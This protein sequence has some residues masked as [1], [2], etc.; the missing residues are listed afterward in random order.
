VTSLGPRVTLLLLSFFFLPQPEDCAQKFKDIIEDFTH[1]TRLEALLLTIHSPDPLQ[2][3]NDDTYDH[4]DDAKA[5]S[6]TAFEIAQLFLRV[7]PS[8]ARVA[9]RVVWW[10]QS[11]GPIPCFVR[12]DNGM[13]K[14]EGFDILT[15]RSWEER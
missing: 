4:T 13:A 14:L 10:W 6:L 1:L 2:A 3:D 9:I 5:I 8:L 12:S 15:E 7:C 11:Q